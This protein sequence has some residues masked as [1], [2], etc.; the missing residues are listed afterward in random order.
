MFA[1]MKSEE[2]HTLETN[3]LGEAV[4]VAGKRLE[5]NTTKIVAVVCAVLLI[6]AGITWWMRQTSS[7]GVAAWTLLENAETVAQYS[8]IREKYSGTIPGR[9][10]QLLESELYLKTGLEQM[11]SDRELGAGDLKKAINGFQELNSTK[12]DQAIHERA[13]WGLA[14][15]LEATSDGDTTKASEAYQRLLN[16]VPDTTYRP[17]AE[18]RIAAL[19]TGGVK[20]FYAWFS[21]QNPKPADVRPKDGGFKD[22]FDSMLPPAKSEFNLKPN[23]E[24]P[25]EGQDEKTK[26]EE[27][28]PA[29]EGEKSEAKPDAPAAKEEPK[30]EEKPKIEEKPATEKEV[31]PKTDKPADKKE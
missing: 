17:I 24:K 2:R 8:D 7:S 3:Q 9:W 6:A 5:D 30:V 11:F 27:A 16:D 12:A 13:L 14:L 22:D 23:S 28:K 1:S 10:A 31:E 15:A 4:Q 29:I 18:Q 25:A 26:T 20:D 21:K 19:K